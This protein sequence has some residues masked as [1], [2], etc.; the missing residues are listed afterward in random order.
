MMESRRSQI[1]TADLSFLCRVAVFSL[2]GTILLYL[3]EKCKKRKLDLLIRPI[4]SPCSCV[5]YEFFSLLKAEGFPQLPPGHCFTC[6]NISGS[7]ALL[8]IS[9]L[10]FPGLFLCASVQAA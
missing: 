9:C 7:V 5:I 3:H 8:S 6:G 10:V 2:S 1:Q 4:Y